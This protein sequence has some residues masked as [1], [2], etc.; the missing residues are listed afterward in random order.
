[1]LYCILFIF[2]ILGPSMS[3]V[4]HVKAIKEPINIDGRGTDPSWQQANNLDRFQD[5]WGL[6]EIQKTSFR[7]MHSE[8][9]LHFLFVVE[10]SNIVAHGDPADKRGVLTA[11]RVEIFFKSNGD[12]K[13][14][15]CLEMDPWGRVLDYRSN[16]YRQPEFDWEWPEEDLVVF[17]SI[18]PSGYI[19]E[20][21][22][23]LNSLREMNILEDGK[24]E[25]GVFRGDFSNVGSI[26]PV[27]R[28]I[29]WIN[30]D[31]EKPDF[32]VPTAFGALIL[33]E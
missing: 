13:P 14:Y 32:H 26:D 22:I 12:M 4:Y 33:Q 31:T 27:V 19:V 17:A 18:N 30:P 21:Q 5:P 6:E 1:M 3:N 10:D 28:W 8:D 29:T 20:G 7:A 2:A 23:S 11:D 15:Y 24:I 16:Y 25:A 9:Y